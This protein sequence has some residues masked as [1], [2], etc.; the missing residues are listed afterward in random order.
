MRQEARITMTTATRRTKR[1]KRTNRAP[2]KRTPLRSQPTSAPKTL[3]AAALDRFGGPSV[4]TMHELPMPAVGANEV[5]I[6]LRAAGVGSWDAEM[7]HGWSPSGRT[8]FPLVLGSDGAGTVA[9]LGASVRRFEIGE[10]VYAYSFDN[11]KGGFYADHVVVPAERVARVPERLDDLQAGG[12]GTTGLTALQGVDDALHVARGETLIIHGGSGGVGTLAVQ[13]ARARGARVLTTASGKEGVALVRRLGAEA[14]VDGKRGDLVAAARRFAPEGVDA[15]LALAGGPALTQCLDALR[16]GGRL[17]Y[18]HGIEPAPKK[19]AGLK[20]IVY[21]AVPGVRELQ[22][23]GRA[24]ESARL[25]VPIAK[26]FP[27][28]QAAKAHARL[29]EG[30]VLGKIVLEIR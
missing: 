28:A 30:H 26:V 8:H 10:R 2:A 22:R 27:L 19:R 4:L 6:A 1:T 5:L 7:R 15:V 21:D 12:L 18:P 29:A 3:K 25:E 11:P 17:A 20:V 9:A 14:A 23:L 16:R 24:V 13:F